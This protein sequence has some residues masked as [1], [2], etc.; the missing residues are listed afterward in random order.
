MLDTIS[1]YGRVN[2]ERITKKYGSSNYATA[3]TDMIDNQ[4]TD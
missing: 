2:I 3:L 1:D 4:E